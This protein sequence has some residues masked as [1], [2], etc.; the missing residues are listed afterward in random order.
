MKIKIIKPC[1]VNGKPAYAGS[2][3]EVKTTDAKTLKDI[4]K[5]IDAPAEEAKPEVKKNV[6]RTTKR[7]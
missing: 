4:G 3:V 6:K 2:V 7:K 5:A 1:Y